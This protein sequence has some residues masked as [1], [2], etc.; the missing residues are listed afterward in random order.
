MP[1][2]DKQTIRGIIINTLFKDID[3]TIKPNITP[4]HGSCC[5]CQKCGYNYDECNCDVRDIVKGLDQAESQIKALMDEKEIAKI[6]H[7]EFSDGS[8]DWETMKD[9]Y[10]KIY[11][12][13]AHA[14]KEW[15]EKK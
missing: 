6:L 13:K 3:L 12:D 10:K 7:F 9:W 2:P 4:G 11:L 15:W 5:T 8:T 1:K 14:I